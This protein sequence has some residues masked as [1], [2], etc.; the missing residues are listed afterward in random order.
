MISAIHHAALRVRNLGEAQ[1]RWSRL[2][3][4]TTER[5]G[6]LALLRCAHEDYAL[7]LHESSARPGVEYVAYE[8]ERDLTVD[9]ADARLRARGIEPRELDLPG[10]GR[11]LRLDDPDGNGVVLAPWHRRPNDAWPSEVQFSNVLPGFHPRKFGHVNYLTGDARHIVD[12]YIEV[13]GFRLT[14]WIGSE[15]A[16]LHVNA[17]HH[18]LAFLEKGFAHVHHLAFELVDWGEMRVALDHLAQ[19]R[20]PVVWGPGRHGMAR[21]LFSY[22]RMPEE[23]MFVELY[24]DMEQLP[25]HHEPRY[26]EDTPHSSNTWGVLPPRSYFRFDDEA[27]A[28]E[29]AQTE[30]YGVDKTSA[31][32]P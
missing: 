2:L 9:A 4:L 29:Q 20:R 3:G 6:E 1:A 32:A 18:V 12:W 8:L 5:A 31:A 26:Y 14:D 19:H 24:A 15:G 21:N 16:W 25:A 7:L 11:A 13:L 22:W 10:R 27:I 17:D 23:D 30:A 28:S